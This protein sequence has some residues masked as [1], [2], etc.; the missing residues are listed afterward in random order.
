MMVKG[1]TLMT[2]TSQNKTLEDIEFIKAY[3]STLKNEMFKLGANDQD[4]NRIKDATIRN[5]L[6][7]NRRPEDVAWALLQ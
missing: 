5:A 7:R 2:T 4:L 1:V 3:H 6:K